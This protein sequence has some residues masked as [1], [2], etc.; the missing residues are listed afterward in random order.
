[1]DK[2]LYPECETCGSKM[3]PVYFLEEEYEG[4]VKTGRKRRAVSHFECPWCGKKKCV[5]DSFD[6]PWF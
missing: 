4:P 6:G 1:M 3:E 5:D 2:E